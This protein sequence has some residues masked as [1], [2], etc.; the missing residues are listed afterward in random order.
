LTIKLPDGYQLKWRGQLEQL[1]IAS[2][3]LMIVVPAA[4]TLIFVLLYLN[5]QATFRALVIFLNNS[6][7]S[8]RE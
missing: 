5:F 6:L 4:L 1:E 8:P 2:Q 7:L 3:R